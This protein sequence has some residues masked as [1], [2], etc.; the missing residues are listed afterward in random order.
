[1]VQKISTEGAAE[2]DLNATEVT[3]IPTKEK[4][5]EKSGLY[6]LIPKRYYGRIAPRSDLEL[7]KFIDIGADVI[8]EDYR[9]EIDIILFNFGEQDFEVKI[10][11][12]IAQLIFQYV[13]KHL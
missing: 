1:M 11:D 7:K 10:G 6:I 13:L 4:S 3:I 8:D 9:G 2:Y 5:L 12:R